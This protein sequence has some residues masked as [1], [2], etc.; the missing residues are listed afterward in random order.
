MASADTSTPSGGGAGLYLTVPAPQMA[1]SVPAEEEHFFRRRRNNSRP[2]LFLARI[3]RINVIAWKGGPRLMLWRARLPSEG[4]W[5]HLSA[6]ELSER[7]RGRVGGGNASSRFE[8]ENTHTHTRW[9]CRWFIEAPTTIRGSEM[10]NGYFQQ[11]PGVS[12]NCG[13]Q[14]IV[15]APRRLWEGKSGNEKCLIVLLKLQRAVMAV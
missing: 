1:H 11:L 8:V 6:P 3:P 9:C 14:A 4:C 10:G 7:V 2:S 5:V 12:G 13:G 15:T